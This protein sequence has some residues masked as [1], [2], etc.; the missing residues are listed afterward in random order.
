MWF[1][2]PTQFAIH[3]QWWSMRRMHDLQTRQWWHR[4]GLNLSHHLQKRRPPLFGISAALRLAPE[5][6]G[7]W[8]N[9][10][11]HCLPQFMGPASKLAEASPHLAK[12]T[13]NYSVGAAASWIEPAGP[14]CAPRLS[15]LHDWFNQPGG[16]FEQHKGCL[17]E[18]LAD[19]SSTKLRVPTN[20]GHVRRIWGW[21]RP[22]VGR[23][24]EARG[25]SPKAAEL[26]D[27]DIWRPGKQPGG[28]TH[29]SERSRPRKRV[30]PTSGVDVGL[31][32]CARN[33][34]RAFARGAISCRRRV[35]LIT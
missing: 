7:Q 25:L 10:G 18:L 13:H 34:P 27:P 12:A 19:R 11:R 30:D 1:L 33:E 2:K 14:P 21:F 31:E 29:L 3:G 22:I 16:G 6:S 24:R 23:L 26:V 9:F 4:S 32:S 17:D 35:A 15:F 5:L 8:S 28:A 20:C